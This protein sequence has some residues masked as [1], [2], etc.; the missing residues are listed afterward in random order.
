MPENAANSTPPANIDNELPNV[1]PELNIP[2]ALP[3]SL[4]AKKSAMIEQAPGSNAASP[5]ATR[6]LAMSRCQNSVASPQLA[7]ARLHTRMPR[8][9]IRRRLPASIIRAI[10]NPM[11][12]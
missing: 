8:L 12:E 3:R 10:G 2:I 4:G 7:V 5:V 9:M 11:T 1:P 6:V